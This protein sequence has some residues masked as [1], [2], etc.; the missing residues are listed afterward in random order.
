M[1]HAGRRENSSK[2]SSAWKHRRRKT[3]WK[4]RWLELRLQ[5]LQHQQT[6]YGE[7]LAALRQR[8][9]A[10]A[11]TPAEASRGPASPLDVPSSALLEA[12]TQLENNTPADASEPRLGDTGEEQPGSIVPLAAAT[13]KGAAGRQ[14]SAGDFDR[15]G[16]SVRHRRRHDRQQARELAAP[17]LLEHPFFAALAG[18]RNP[19][20]VCRA[21]L[22]KGVCSG[23]IYT[24]VCI[25]KSNLNLLLL[26]YR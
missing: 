7:Q 2:R 21:M 15:D 16:L 23:G 9:A 17:H 13:P 19:K 12:G 3:E 22:Q 10:E 18:V 1:C 20:Q 25:K 5:E 26:N 14:N 6:R 11:S 4:A 8:T 24:P